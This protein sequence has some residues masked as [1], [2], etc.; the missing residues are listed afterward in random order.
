MKN[1]WRI[2]KNGLASLLYNFQLDPILGAYKIYSN[3]L[4]V[5]IHKKIPSPSLT[6]WTVHVLIHFAVFDRTKFKINAFQVGNATL[7]DRMNS[8]N[9]WYILL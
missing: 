2:V 3:K 7:S 4:C 9:L 6:F 5:L 8:M 1:T